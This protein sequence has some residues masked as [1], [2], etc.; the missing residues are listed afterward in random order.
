MLVIPDKITKKKTDAMTGRLYKILE[1]VLD[2]AAPLQYR[3]DKI[4]ANKWFT[5]DLVKHRAKVRKLYYR[6]MR[7]RGHVQLQ[8]YKAEQKRFK[9]RCAKAKLK[10]WRY[11]VET[12][13]DESRMAILN[14]IIQGK[15][16][17]SIN[18]LQKPDGTDT[19]PGLPTLQ[20]L[21]DTHFPQAT[22]EI[23]RVTYNADD[24]VM[25]DQLDDRIPWIS[26]YLTRRALK[27]KYLPKNFL[28]YLSALYQSLSLIH[29]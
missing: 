7:S 9:K 2:E 18:T 28:E 24:Y 16:Q 11:F 23:P 19:E 17:K 5:K 22:L 25:A 13:P 4:K 8:T 20:L 27:A 29:I 15:S 21:V 10:S 3:S 14:K 1:K 12:T 26:P 6:A